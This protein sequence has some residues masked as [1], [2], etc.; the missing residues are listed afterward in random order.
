MDVTRV[1]EERIARSAAGNAGAVSLLARDLWQEVTAA[2]RARYGTAIAE[3]W[4][5]QITPTFFAKGVYA[6]AV[7]NDVV[8]EW[9]DHRYRAEIEA[10]LR[11][12]TGS[13]IRVQLKVDAGK[14]LLSRDPDVDGIE[15]EAAGAA[16]LAPAI[17]PENR[18]ANAALARLLAD[19]ST[20]NPLFLYGAQGTGKS[21]LVRHHLEQYAAQGNGTR[22]TVSIAAEAFSQGLVRALREN[23][24]SAYRGRMLAADVLVLEEAHRLR[25]KPRTQREF[26]S[27]LRYLVARGRPVILTSR[28]PPNGI[29]LLDEAVRSYFLSGILV[30][31]QD[32]ADPSRLAILEERASR[33]ARKVPGPTLERIVAR[34]GGS[35]DRQ[36]RFLEKVAAFAALSER[37]A[38]LEFLADKFPEL[39]GK[40]GSEIDIKDLIDQAAREF[41]TT[42]E[43]VASNRKIRTAVLARHVVVYVATEVLGMKAN[44]VMRHLGGLSPS[45]T[46]YARRRVEGLRRDDSLFDARIR[47]LLERLGRGQR[48][49]F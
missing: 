17:R 37:E 47:Q 3:L 24:L 43:D 33:F 29:F 25:G 19:P 13:P 23:E 30:R 8:R 44:R 21:H 34:V 20:G 49:L 4:L 6:L 1:V 26:L 7:P 10:I 28:H 27:I 15:V 42:P 2:F 32:Y 14:P 9:L 35:L 11:D 18:H 40:G 41:G 45:T 31:I 36:V 48:M 12:L 38:T 16:T 22:T 5:P 39:A 46:A